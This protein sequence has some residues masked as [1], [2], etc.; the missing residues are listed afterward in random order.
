[1]HADVDRLER[2]ETLEGD[3][4]VT[5]AAG[6]FHNAQWKISETGL[7]GTI[8]S[9]TLCNHTSLTLM[10]VN[11]CQGYSSMVQVLLYCLE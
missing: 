10:T 9:S 7:C 5:N 1:M 2:L 6:C 3:K 8:S 4:D 11:Q